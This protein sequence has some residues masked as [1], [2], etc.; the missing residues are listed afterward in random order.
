M[1]VKKQEKE[2]KAVFPYSYMQKA[3]HAKFLADL[4]SKSIDILRPASRQ[5]FEVEI[6]AKIC[7]DSILRANV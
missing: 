5:E 2:S 3:R 6:K 7:M 4:H 1:K